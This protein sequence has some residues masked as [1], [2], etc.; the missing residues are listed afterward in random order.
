VRTEEDITAI[1]D[2]VLDIEA[3]VDAHTDVTT[4]TE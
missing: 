1:G 2:T 3:T 4:V